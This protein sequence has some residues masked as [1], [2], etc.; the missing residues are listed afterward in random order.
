M[1]IKIS[2]DTDIVTS[3]AG[4]IGFAPRES[5]VTIMLTNDQQM[6][7]TARH[8]IAD[9]KLHN[10]G[11]VGESLDAQSAIVV[12]V[13]EELDAA[14]V[15]QLAAQATTVYAAHGIAVVR[16]LHA[17]VI[18]YG[19]RWTNLDTK[20]TGLVDDPDASTAGLYS[21]LTG[22][23]PTDS[24][25]TLV[26]DI[27]R[28]VAEY[29]GDDY[30]RITAS[31]ALDE[32]ST[33]ITHGTP[34]EV[35][36]DELAKSLATYSRMG[37]FRDAILRLALSERGAAAEALIELARHLRGQDRAHLLTAAA[38]AIYLT[39]NGGKARMLLDAARTAADGDLLGIGMILTRVLESG[40]P[41]EIL[42]E[43]IA[44]TD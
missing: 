4:V 34:T 24:R 25:E 41:P 38:A 42:A 17:P 39:G 27:E 22:G 7:F 9:N 3:A 1:A 44:A 14:D 37:G 30:A 12:I 6:A 26:A 20:D 28:T 32:L 2:T 15:E 11:A 8:D 43:A 33:V 29:T 31:R 36:P 35:A 21:R 40:I 13:S 10:V 16:R 5:I 18:Q 19:A 23:A